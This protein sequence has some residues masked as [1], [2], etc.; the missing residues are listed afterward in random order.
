MMKTRTV[1]SLEKLGLVL[2]LSVLAPL[3][4]YTDALWR[5]NYLLYDYELKLF[6]RPA[7][8]DVLIVAIDEHSLA[9]LGR[10]PWPR[11]LHAQLL[12]RLTEAGA[13]GVALDIVFAEPAADDPMGDALLAQALRKNGHVVLPVLPE[14][15]RGQLVETLPLP[16]LAEAAA[17]LGHIDIELDRDGIVRN[18]YLKA[19]LGKPHWPSLGLA[20]LEQEQP[21]AWNRLAEKIPA[22]GHTASPYAWVRDYRIGIPFAGPPGHFQQLSFVDVVSGRVP[23][24]VLRDKLILV[25]V[26]ASGLG[27][28]L[29]TPVSGLSQPMSGAEIHAN[30]LDALRRGQVIKFLT[31]PWQL[32]LTLMLVL[33]ATLLYSQAT[34]PRRVLLMTFGLLLLTLAGSALLLV[35]AG[36][37]F[38]PAPALLAISLSYP[39]WS[40]RRLEY[41]LRSLAQEK[42]R[43]EVTLQSIGDAV[44]TTDADGKVNYL[45]PTAERMT[46][47]TLA[48]ARD[49]PLDTVVRLIDQ[50]Q[51]N[52]LALGLDRCLEP[53]ESGGSERQGN[54]LISRSGE[55][56]TIRDLTAP[57]RSGGQVFGTVLAISNV[58]ETYRLAER[59]AY[60]ANHDTLTRLPNRN[61]LLDRL[62]H[63]L[64]LSQR[65]GGWVAVL[66]IDLDNFKQVNDSLGHA[67]GDA[68][69]R[70][71]SE[72]LSGCVR[73]HDTLARLGGDE[74]ILVLENLPREELAAAVARKILEVLQ[75]PFL[76]GGHEFFISSSIG[77]SLFPKDG[78]DRETLLRNADM[79]MYRAK[80]QGRNNFQFYS[81]WMND[82]VIE[83]LYLENGL[84]YAMERNELLLYYQP[85]VD[86]ASR[87]VVGVEALIRWRHS[88]QGLISP[89]KFIPLAEETGLI[90]PIGAW[91]IE[92]ACIQA[93][94]WQDAGLSLR[95]AV[96]L[97]ARQFTQ[98]NLIDSIITTLQRTG[99]KADCLKLEIT[100]SLLMEDVEKVITTLRALKAIGVKI[101]ID[102]FGTG[103]SS[104]SYLKRFP[105]DFLK[106][107]R[108]FIRDIQSDPDDAAIT[109]AILAMAHSMHLEVIAEG[110]ET[111]EQLAFLHAHHCKEV[112]GFYFS[113]PAPADTVT[114]LVRQRGAL[115][116][117]E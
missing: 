17:D 71:V 65:S 104:L 39:L 97:S 78:V 82:H 22:L 15:L 57:M 9:E 80:E 53:G 95:V 6:F 90:V 21:A 106:I 30:V 113:P 19:G 23:A 2:L 14:Q 27:P 11:R 33:A 50:K 88:A 63:A 46:G 83:R 28:A 66:F 43:V 105:L 114:Q 7:P 12:D 67:A 40:W 96:N 55:E 3:L 117:P 91:V 72:R 85:Q 45:N 41:T 77:I 108:S 98:P 84:R 102:D 56:Y 94:L 60:Q 38:A 93:K 115:P 51:R 58:T 31:V 75:P 111:D 79:A 68:L 73:N 86:L 103:Y 101:A 8:V 59:L 99:L 25:G 64:A 87:T 36:W 49:Q 37:W 44:I 35:T 62:D 1:L 5:W 26:T 92:T 100:E 16:L 76:L 20:L 4:V 54:L 52:T 32:A 70:A 81:K 18:S 69:L 34:P 10:W 107:D 116:V 13:A 29:P 109:L 110:V 89:A 112:Q 61:L 24:E 42:E 74:F 48:E 47:W